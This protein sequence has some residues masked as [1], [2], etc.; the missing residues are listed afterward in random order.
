MNVRDRKEVL[1]RLLIWSVAAAVAFPLGAQAAPTRA[2]L[3]VT[4]V[5]LFSSGVGYFEHSARLSGDVFTV[6]PFE[7]AAVNDVLKSLIINDPSAVSPSVTY[8][9]EET[10][11]RTLKSLKIDVSGNPGI[12]QILSGVQGAG[13]RVQT[14]SEITG[15]IIGVE[16]RTDADGTST[17]SFLSLLTAEGIRVISLAEI[18]NFAFTDRAMNEDLA[19][20]LDLILQ[21]RDSLTRNLQVNLPGKGERQVSIGYVVPAPVWKVSYRL[22]LSGAAPRLQGWAIV[23]NAG[24]MDWT[25][26]RLSLVTGRPVSF[27]QN[28]YE[29]L[30]PVRPVIPLSIAGVA[31]A[32]TYESGF[33]AEAYADSPAPSA[34]PEMAYAMKSARPMAKSMDLEESAVAGLG[35]NSSYETASGRAAGDQFEFTVSKPVSLARQQSAMIPLVES[36]VKAEK[37]SVFSGARAQQGQ[38]M[39][40]MLCA[41]IT[42]SSG[43]KLPAGPITVFD[44]GSYAGDALVEFFPENEKRII[45]FGEDLSVSGSAATVSA[46]EMTGVTVSRGVMTIARRTTWTRTYTF[47]NA[48]AKEK[49]LIVEHPLISGAVLA[50]PAKADE[51]TD[52]AYRFRIALPAGSER[53]FVVREQ[54]P[55]QETVV[56]SQLRL[57]SFL[58]YTS[59]KEVPAKVKD[60]LSKAVEFKRKA[61]DAQKSLDAL[62]EK[63]NE[64]IA[65]QGRIRDNISAAGN[66]SQQGKEYLKRLAAAD[67]EIDSLSAR[68]DA[69]RGAV[70]DARAAYDSYLSGLTLE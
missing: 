4:R 56:L 13:L 1:H 30:R 22:D 52:D 21:S 58:Y 60:A 39:H 28:L 25:N 46:Q 49:K 24:D 11:Y 29:P 59:S 36:P 40:P 9:S 47:K 69:A 32:Q 53:T 51:K 14:T 70:K 19:R 43:M 61:D 41:E 33:G 3:P 48:G 15:R 44:D 18:S 42:N 35:A 55:A 26:V 20:A 37:F 65:E 16:T 5:S 2:D 7:M 57:D 66:D 10:L 17:E 6:L 63:R 50:E 38:I 27:I 31:E 34:A 62:V 8:P 54:S 68:I 23:D 67:A 12:A 64:K 45:A